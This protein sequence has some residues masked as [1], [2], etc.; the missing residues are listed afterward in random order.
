MM[1][2]KRLCAVLMCAVLVCGLLPARASA[3]TA[4]GVYLATMNTY[5][6][7]PDTGAI[8]DPGGSANEALGAEM[9]R[10]ATGKQCLVEVADGEIWITVRLN[11]QNSCSSVTLSTRTGSNQYAKA[12]ARVV[13]EKQGGDTADYRI[14]VKSVDQKIKCQM[15]VDPM[16]REVVWYMGA[17][18]LKEGHGD[19]KVTIDLSKPEPEKPAP[20]P[21]PKP[22][23]KPEKPAPQP[24]KPQPK[25]EKPA[26][27]PSKPAEKPAK[28]EQK[29]AEKPAKPEQKPAEPAKPAEKPSKPVEKPD[30]SQPDQT[31]V[32]P[33]PDVSGSSSADQSA[34]SGADVSADASVD[35]SAADSSA[36]ED[37]EESGFP[38]G[39]VLLILGAAAVAAAVVVYKRKK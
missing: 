29:P 32:A 15:Y 25:P 14:K 22:E 4:D 27:K 31:V 6:R 38:L 28:P 1:K 9:C 5:Y 3:R 11:M 7:N 39:P 19:F 36:Q 35:S 33:A 30:A 20:Q 2:L 12:R 17:S 13:S 8:D 26:E 21:E 37:R 23:P 18:G 34:A 24:E 16:G 10:G